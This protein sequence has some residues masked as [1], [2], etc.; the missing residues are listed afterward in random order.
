M[1]RVAQEAL[2]NAMRHSGAA[3]A[4]VELGVADGRFMV[5]VRDDGAG[6]DAAEVL[7]HA[8]AGRGIGLVG[9]QERVALAGG[10]MD[11]RARTAQGCT[12][13]AS[14]PVSGTRAEA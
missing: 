12:V 2:T 10:T 14:F 5:S 11:I 4:W 6:F 7:E 9:M 8:A 1:F 13:T 3:N